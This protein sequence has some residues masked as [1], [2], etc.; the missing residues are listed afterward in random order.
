[1]KLLNRLRGRIS[2]H[3]DLFRI[4]VV[5]AAAGLLVVLFVVTQP[6]DLR[7]HNTL[8]GYFSQLQSDEARLGEAVLTLN[9]SLSNNYDQ[10]T[11]IN[12][13]LRHTV[14]ELRDGE[15]ANPLRQ[16][17]EAQQQLDL[18]DQ[19]LTTKTNAL[20]KFKSLNSVLK[21]SL[22]YL[23]HV[24]DEL[25]RDL[26]KPS[27]VDEQ[28][29]D[30]V[31]YV[32][33]N[34]INGA[35][36]ERGG[37]ETSIAAL[38]TA[39]QKFSPATQRKANNLIRHLR[40]IDRFERALPVLVQELTSH[41]ESSGIELA[42]RDH[43][44][45][46]QQRATVYRIFLL[47][48]T[49]AL[50]GY[51][52]R[53][54]FRLREQASRLKLAAS[55]FATASEGI[56]ITDTHGTILEVN[57]AFTR[58][59]GYTRAEV[60][61]KN[62]RIL[63]SGRQSAAF[64]ENM[65]RAIKMHGQWQGEIWNRR[66]NGEEYAEWLT[67][68]IGNTQ[69]GEQA[70]VTHYVAS[71][72][73]LTQ[74]KQDEAKIHQLAFYDP[75]TNLPNR[76]LL[77]E[78]LEHALALHDERAGL[79]SLLFVDIDNFKTINDIKGHDVGDLLLVEIG[80]RL[81]SCSRE[82]DT[83]ARMGGDKFVIMLTGLSTQPEQA[84]AQAKATSEMVQQLMGQ[85]CWLK[86]FEHRSACSIGISMFAPYVSAEAMLQHADTAMYE[87]KAAGRNA[88]RFFDPAMQRALETR[89]TLESN[90]HL[91]IAQQQF[92]LY[93]QI[94][95]NTDQQPI[96]AE[97]LV[98]WK[99]PQQGLISPAVFIPL[100][101]ETGLILPL[102]QW[103]LETACTQLKAWEAQAHTRDLVLAVNV[104]GRQ[105]GADDFVNQIESLL[106]SSAIEPSRLKLEITES[107]LLGNIENVISTM[108]QLKALGVSFSMDDFGTG[109]SSLQYLKR[110]PLDQLKIDQS[111]VRDIANDSNDQAIV[112]TIIAMAHSM[113]LNIIAE[114]VETEQQRELL[115]RSGC[116][117][118][119]GYLFSK[120][121]PIDEFDVL[122][123]HTKPQ[124][125]ENT[126]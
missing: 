75:L 41:P 63:Q 86:D 92:V 35:L 106:A 125:Q 15:A 33:L 30:L 103:V 116:A 118:F 29:D 94:Q 54:F 2:D 18:L 124:V 111:F 1:M 82:G 28:V 61:G 72:S 34:R 87:A 110:L 99:H 42:Y 114:G 71:F 44:E 76:R 83:V 104:S 13:H 21:N 53:T 24:R 81:L 55:V 105:F 62:P 50:L 70:K 93:Y 23:P 9:F 40:Q 69:T 11:A 17:L 46:L 115:T 126:A 52:A 25:V 22:I 102:G 47:L 112:R 7:R 88:L 74:H 68:T 31:E 84:A 79:A 119:Q 56:T 80:K 26:P 98:R 78:R 20:E 85:P 109:Y 107:M 97:A 89:A 108:R 36:L 19:R 60:I 66:K 48:A 8:L 73:D 65:W 6:V 27:E 101:E 16:D 117:N 59:T 121:L 4:G 67:I 123:R 77:M 95:V 38:E 49:L 43:Y 58:V 14:R 113:N 120:P 91:A 96:G 51:A 122:C 3:A 45:R 5:A 100:A 37:L 57:A 10:V 12:S 64:Y 90:L 39:T 32:L